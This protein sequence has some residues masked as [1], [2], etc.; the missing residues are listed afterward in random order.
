MAHRLPFERV[1]ILSPAHTFTQPQNLNFDRQMQAELHAWHAVA[2]SRGADAVY[3][4]VHG[5]AAAPALLQ[6]LVDMGAR[7]LA[8]A[9]H[10]D[11]ALAPIAW[12]HW[13]GTD[14]SEHLPAFQHGSSPLRGISCHSLQDLE[15]AADF[16]FDYAFLSP[17]FATA[18]HPEARPL[19][20]DLLALACKSARLPVIALGGI[21]FG[22]ASACLAAGA[23]GWAGIRCWL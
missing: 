3:A 18:T 20:L 5:M 9:S 6:M 19:G 7:V 22:N 12:H 23:A 14:L 2:V 16:G 13:S 4:R 10:Y 11:A 21:D 8:P 17:I 1:A 15:T